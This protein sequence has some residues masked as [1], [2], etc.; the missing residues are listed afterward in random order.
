MALAV[1]KRDLGVKAKTLREEGKLVGVMYG[2]NHESIPVVAD[3]QSFRKEFR[4]TGKALVMELE[5][6]GKNI[7]TLVHDIEFEP[8]SGNYEHVDFLVVNENE[9][10]HA[11]VPLRLEGLAP[12]VKNLSAVLTTPVKQLEIAC[13]PKD[14]LKEVVV[15]VMSIEKFHQSIHVR[16][17]PIFSDERYTLFA[18]PAGVVVASSAPRGVKLDAEGNIISDA[19]A[20]TTDK[21]KKK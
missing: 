17:L 11:F 18:D 4:T 3:Y 10:I 5:L 19:P 8:V 1:Q 2:H 20:A 6:D 16:D 7:S 12:A 14:L 13:L 21:K 15:D 9:K